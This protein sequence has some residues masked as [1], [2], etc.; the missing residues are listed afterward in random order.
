MELENPN[1]TLY[2][3]IIENTISND[4]ILNNEM[5]EHKI[6]EIVKHFILIINESTQKSIGKILIHF[7]ENLVPWLEECSY[8]IKKIMKCTRQI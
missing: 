2:S 6:V 3:D 8:A 4:K 5:N 1:W 7:G